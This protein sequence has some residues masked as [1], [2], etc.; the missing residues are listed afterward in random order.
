[1]NTEH[2]ALLFQDMNICIT[3][4]LWFMEILSVNM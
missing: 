1:M 3:I 2:P 4:D